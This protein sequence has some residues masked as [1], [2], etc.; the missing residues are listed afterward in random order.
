MIESTEH[1]SLPDPLTVA[2]REDEIDALLERE[3]LL[4]NKIGAYASSTVIGCNTRRYHGLL[5]A[6]D[7][8]PAGRIATLA[9]VMEELVVD[10]Q[11]YEL[12]VNEFPGSFTP[13]G[14]THLA[15]FRNDAAITFVY[16]VGGAELTKEIVLAESAN[17]VALR[18]T[19]RGAAG[20][21]CL[22][23]FVALRSY[24]ELRRTDDPHNITF[25]TEPEGVVVQDR[26][27][28]F[29][30]LHL[31]SKEADFDTGPEWWRQFRY[32]TD[33]ARGQDGLE[34]LYTPGRFRYTLGEGESCQFT[35]SLRDPVPVG[36]ATTIDRRRDR[37]ASLAGAGS[38][39]L[40]RRLAV[41]TDAFPVKRYFPDTAPSTTILAGYPWFADWGR[42]A[43]IALPGLLLSTRRFD[44]AREAFRTFGEHLGEGMVP[45]RFDEYSSAAH[46]NSIDASLWYIAAAGRY[47]EAGDDGNFWRNFLMPTCDTILRAYQQGTQFDIHADADGLLTGGSDRTQLTW[48][49]AALGDEVVTSRNGKAVEVNALWHSAHRMMAQQCRGVDDALADHYAHQADLIGPAFVRAFWFEDGRYLYDCV[50]P[51]GS[52]ASI[53][54]NQ[55][56]AVS[57]PHSP[58]SPDQQADVVRT[59]TK[60]LLTPRGLRTLSPEDDNYRGRYG[61][62]WES[63]DRAY[64]Q[65]TVWAWLIGGFI[66]A[67]LKVE[68]F[69]PF[70]LAQ[71]QQW[72]DG[73]AEHLNE[74]CLGHISEIFD[75]DAPHAPRGC[76][77]QAWSVAEVLRALQLVRQHAGAA[78][79]SETS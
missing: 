39:E 41:A 35:A 15:E 37:L 4:S 44:V 62:S 49:D 28:A 71:A 3:W 63:R 76:S 59:V 13:G 27:A 40:S 30:E 8:A 68:N 21:L 43:F 7:P 29:P 36:V 17:A 78:E 33:I 66:E 26:D 75:G 53:R 5:I 77:A 18:Y 61:G 65:G 56:F 67:Y 72:L 70:A 74:A 34:D 31:L 14:I 69:T 46:Y 1:A 32:R 22:R 9:T 47:V 12:A 25:A 2:V 42:D 79:A 20:E 6:A 54:P 64:H 73:F 48:M 51:G 57:L 23:P 10:G 38:D 24:H 19:L 45:N 16:R 52:D 11:R 58:L 50:G 60:H 55:I